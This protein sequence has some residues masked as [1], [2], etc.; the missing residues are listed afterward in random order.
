MVRGGIAVLKTYDELKMNIE[1]QND[2]HIF[3]MKLKCVFF[4]LFFDFI[5]DFT[6]SHCDRSKQG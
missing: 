1:C 3:A 2:I 5:E 4:Y 6:P